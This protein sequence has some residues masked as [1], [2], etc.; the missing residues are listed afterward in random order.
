MFTCRRSGRFGSCT[1]NA[2]VGALEFIEMKDKVATFQ[3]LSRLFVY[4]NERVIEHS[5]NSDAGAEIRDG[6]KSLNTQGCCP[7][8]EWPYDITKFTVKPTAICYTDALNHK[9]TSYAR[10]LTLNDMKTCLAS[11]YP[12]VFG[13]S[14]Y[15]SFESAQVAQTGIV[16]MPTRR[17]RVLGGHAVLAV[18][19]DDSTQRFLVKNSWG[20]DWGM[21]D[22]FTIPYTYLT[23]RNLADD[24][25]VINTEHG[26]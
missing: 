26:Y 1:A 15:S 24:F 4:Y 16:N 9:I 6:I 14:V 21:K 18:G 20:V 25:W 7:E 3:D 13:F 12:F 19:Y 17:E 10:I 2:L 11:G 23:S 5:I 22:Y 8:S